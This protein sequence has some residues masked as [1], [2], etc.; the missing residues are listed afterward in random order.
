LFILLS[1]ILCIPFKL[2]KNTGHLFT[3]TVVLV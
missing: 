1:Q 3:L 2:T